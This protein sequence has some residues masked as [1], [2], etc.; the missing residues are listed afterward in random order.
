MIYFFLRFLFSE[1]IWRVRLIIFVYNKFLY[2]LYIYYIIG[3]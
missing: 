1:E 3:I 2:K